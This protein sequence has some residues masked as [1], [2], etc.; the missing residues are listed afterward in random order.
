MHPEPQFLGCEPG[1]TLFP[2]YAGMPL[3]FVRMIIVPKA[4]GA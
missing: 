2:I 1:K 3:G 4:N